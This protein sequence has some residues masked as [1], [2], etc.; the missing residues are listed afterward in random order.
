MTRN[1]GAPGRKLDGRDR[2]RAGISGDAA[3]EGGN[4]PGESDRSETLPGD[5]S[6]AIDLDTV[7]DRAG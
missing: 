2:R 7:R 5:D 1:S 3:V 4:P 6:S